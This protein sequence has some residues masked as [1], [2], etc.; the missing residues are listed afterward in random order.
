MQLHYTSGMIRL[1][2]RS[3]LPVVNGPKLYRN[4]ALKSPARIYTMRYERKTSSR[5]WQNTRLK[6][7]D[8]LNF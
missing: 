1:S 4:G 7:R 5:K 3:Q 8:K 6:K 2:L